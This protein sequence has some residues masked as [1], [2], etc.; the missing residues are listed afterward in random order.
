[1]QQRENEIEI[2]QKELSSQMEDIKQVAKLYENMYAEQAA[3]ILS[4]I[5]DNS[6]V[7]QILKN[8]SKQKSAEI[9]G[10]MEPKKLQ[11]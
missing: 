6:R 2:L 5:E 8:M 3:S 7:I 9:L 10:L 1:M 11:I 4:E